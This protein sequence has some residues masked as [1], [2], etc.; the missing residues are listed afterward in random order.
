MLLKIV[1]IMQRGGG[2]ALKRA[3]IGAILIEFALA[4]PVLIAIVYYLHDIP[5]YRRTWA[6]AEFI[7]HEISGMIQNIS[8][9]RENKKITQN[10]LRYCVAAAFL[11]FYPG[12]TQF[13]KSYNVFKQPGSVCGRIF[14]VVG[15]ADKTASVKWC[16][17]YQLVY[18]KGD[19]TSPRTMSITKND[20]TK[21]MVKTKNN[22]EPSEI[23]SKLSI[24]PGETKVIIENAMYFSKATDL[25]LTDGHTWADFSPSE[26]Y[27]FLFLTPKP[28]SNTNYFIFHVI[29]TPNPG[30]F[31]ET[32]PG[33]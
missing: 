2:Q 7:T 30:L 17:Q 25:K 14:Y 9:N 31:D 8:Q 16:M 6:K 28:Y 15:N 33:V 32:P 11:S 13:P 20:N 10:D 26:V 23:Y 3:Q 24:N 27:G 12:T 1:T 19:N 29:F 21:L 18:E 4:I 22:V 5:K